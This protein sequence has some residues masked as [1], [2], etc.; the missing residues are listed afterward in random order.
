MSSIS[1]STASQ[2]FVSSKDWKNEFNPSTNPKQTNY[3]IGR[4]DK[5]ISRGRFVNIR[6]WDS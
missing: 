3:P 2:L 6:P 1:A 5:V 4:T